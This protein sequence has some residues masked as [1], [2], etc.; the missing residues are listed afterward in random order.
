MSDFLKT[1][2]TKVKGINPKILWTC[3]GLV[4]VFSTCFLFY[5][6]PNSKAEHDSVMISSSSAQAYSALSSSTN[7]A[8]VQ[9]KNEKKQPVQDRLVFFVDV[10]G[11]VLHSQVVRM[12]SGEIIQSAINRAGGANAD[13]D[14][15]QL[16]LAAA[17]VAGQVIYVPK[18]GE[19]IPEQFAASSVN[20]NASASAGSLEVNARN[21]SDAKIDL[22]QADAERLQ[23][24][25]GI[26]EKKADD[27]IK[28]RD[29]HGRFKTVEDLKNVAGFGDKTVEK[30]KDYVTVQ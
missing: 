22:N 21:S 14:L 9:R 28:Y 29:E 5:L 11:A 26:G 20:S 25:S 23:T 17:V 6:I 27:I 19:E 16:N 24:I 3:T 12:T 1:Y 18:K 8:E 4:L 2:I 15:N 13:A 7:S 30:L 10:K